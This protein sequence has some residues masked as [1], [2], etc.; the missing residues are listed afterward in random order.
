LPLAARHGWRGILAEGDL[1]AARDRSGVA[2]CSNRIQ[3]RAATSG[4]AKAAKRILTAPQIV[5]SLI[6]GRVMQTPFEKGVFMQKLIAILM[7]ALLPAAG[8]AATVK[9]DWTASF[10]DVGFHASMTVDESVLWPYYMGGDHALWYLCTAHP[11]HWLVAPP[12]S[13]TIASNLPDWSDLIFWLAVDEDRNPWD[14]G[15]N[16]YANTW[17]MG[18]GPGASW[19][20]VS[21]PF[22]GREGYGTA[23]LTR[24]EIAPIPIPASAALLIGGVAALSLLRRRSKGTLAKPA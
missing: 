12:E 4:Y 3:A 10:D 13:I 23:S 21:D 9:Y 18:A 11:D 2:T 20:S 7:L 15:M 8:S 14:W 19:F 24:R 22:G 6:Y 17:T 5:G 16:I 1:P